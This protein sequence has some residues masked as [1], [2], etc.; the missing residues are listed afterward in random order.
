MCE[1]SGEVSAQLPNRQ[2]QRTTIREYFVSLFFVCCVSVAIDPFDSADIYLPVQR[3]LFAIIL[4]LMV[5]GG[6][7]FAGDTPSDRETG[8]EGVITVSPAQ[9]GPSRVGAPESKPLA[10]TAFIVESEKG[11][12]ASFT[13]DDQGHFRALVPPG[14]YKVAFKGKRIGIGHFGP[15]DVDVGQGK[16][17][18]VQWNCDSGIR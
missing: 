3:Q 4:P 10:N 16:V 6:F 1:T 14:H 12:V 9:P 5:M 18:K 15:F 2:A 8:I 13:T 11:E 17:T 7:V